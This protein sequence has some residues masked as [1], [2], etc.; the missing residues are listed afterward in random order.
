MQYLIRII[1]GRILHSEGCKVVVFFYVLY[2]YCTESECTDA[3]V[4]LSLHHMSEG[5]FIYVEANIF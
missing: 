5:M 1:T 2:E 3:Y 4:D